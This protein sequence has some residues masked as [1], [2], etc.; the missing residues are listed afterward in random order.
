MNNNENDLKK[1]C[2]SAILGLAIGDALGVPVE[3]QSR[4]S[5]KKRPV[6]IM[7]GPGVHNQP[8]GTWSDD[9]SLT[10]ALIEGWE[11]PYELQTIADEMVKWL[12]HA[13]FTAH[14]KVFDVGNTCREAINNVFN[15]CNP[16]N[17]GIS[18]ETANGN[19][20]LMRILPIAFFL[21]DEKDFE[22]RKN[23]IYDISAITHAHILSKVA[24][25][26]YVE[27]AIQLIN[28]KSLKTAYED[29]MHTLSMYYKSNIQEKYYENFKN[30]FIGNILNMQENDISSSGYVIYTLEATFWC[31][32]QTKTYK[33]AV[34]LAVNLGEDTDTTGACVGGLAGII[35][36]ENSIPQ[37]WKEIIARKNYLEEMSEKLFE[38]CSKKE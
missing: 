24:C 35:Y 26:I 10:L 12:K 17:S 5:L 28:G 16:Y 37:K 13:K 32:F 15:G 3:F 8:P 4:Q 33:D 6:T 36:G 1:M 7:R 23:Y 29:T 11:S 27:F 21:K 2:K 20:S 31:L 18:T 19:G 30:I 38:K 9:T 34:L 14:G 22:K 25:H